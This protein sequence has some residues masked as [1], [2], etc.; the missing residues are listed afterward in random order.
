MIN[1]IL[2]REK[3][4]CNKFKVKD[5]SV[6][7]RKKQ[8]VILQQSMHCL[9]IWLT[10]RKELK[11]AKTAKTNKADGWC[12]IKAKQIKSEDAYECSILLSRKKITRTSKRPTKI[13]EQS[14][15]LK[16]LVRLTKN[17]P[18]VCV[19]VCMCVCLCKSQFWLSLQ[20]VR[21]ER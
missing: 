12:Q 7:L 5:C 3:H 1:L 17:L 16:L 19:C 4:L 18:S 20:A 14:E 15:A 11:G 9:A 13:R 6:T 8:M 2:N 21:R 10:N